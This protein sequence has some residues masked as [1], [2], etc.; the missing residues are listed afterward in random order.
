MCSHFQ[1]LCSFFEKLP[2]TF[3]FFFTS[4]SSLY[5]PLSVNLFVS[6]LAS[7]HMSVCLTNPRAATSARLW[8]RPSAAVGEAALIN[9]TMSAPKR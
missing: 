3:D 6:L 2:L 8:G 9:T 7:V 5:V 1:S 4:F